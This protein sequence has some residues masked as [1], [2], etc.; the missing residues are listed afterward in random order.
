MLFDDWSGLGRV[1]VMA[2]CGYFA[3][4]AMLRLSGKRT[5]TKLSAFDL[6]VTVA[7]GSTLGTMMLSSSVVLAEGVLALAMLVALQFV[8]AWSVSRFPAVEGVARAAPRL[9]YFRGRFL[10]AELRAE[11]LTAG[12]V[13]SRARQRGFASLERVEAIVFEPG[14]DLSILPRDHAPP[15]LL[16]RLHHGGVEGAGDL[17]PTGQRDAAWGG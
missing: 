8:V 17:N 16:A 10:D 13:R 11:R 14:G 5:L 7:L 1:L 9:L 12:E 4:L 15:D 6:V 3:L 2:V